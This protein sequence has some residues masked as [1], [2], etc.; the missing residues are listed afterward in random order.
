MENDV[1]NKSTQ[2]ERFEEVPTGAEEGGKRTISSTGLL[3]SS[4]RYEIVEYIFNGFLRIF[5]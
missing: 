4:R 2:K 1:A 5:Y 3:D